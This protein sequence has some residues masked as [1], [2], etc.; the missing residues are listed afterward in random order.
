MPWP[1]GHDTLWLPTILLILN[2]C[3]RCL[4]IKWIIIPIFRK[5]DNV[6]LWWVSIWH[7]GV[8]MVLACYG[9]IWSSLSLGFSVVTPL[10]YLFKIL[11]ETSLFVVHMNH[12][13]GGNDVRIDM[14]GDLVLYK[15]LDHLLIL[16][17]I[18]FFLTSE[19]MC[20][21]YAT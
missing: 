6:I 3:A 4:F 15:A 9:I 5:W 18:L 7:H 21:C 13:E 20:I 1:L 10:Y 17:R 14:D 2:K 16:L 11:F 19:K 12:N 8:Q